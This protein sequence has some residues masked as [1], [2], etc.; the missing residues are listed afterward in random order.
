M[1]TEE[2]KKILKEGNFSVVFPKARKN[3]K[4]AME[5]AELIDGVKAVASFVDNKDESN[6]SYG[7]IFETV[8]VE[9]NDAEM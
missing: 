8:S 5:L 2:M 4:A 9:G 1:D 3:E 6:I 7:V